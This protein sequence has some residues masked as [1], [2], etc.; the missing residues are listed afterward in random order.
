[1]LGAQAIKAGDA[2]LHRGRRAGEHEHRARTT[3]SRGRIGQK[4]GDTTLKDGVV[5]RRPVV[6][7][8]RLP[9]D[10]AGAVHRREGGAQA[11]RARR[12]SR[13]TSQQKAAAAWAACRF[14]KEIVAVTIP[15]RK[16]DPIV[17]AKDESV[18]A[19]TTL[20]ALAKLPRR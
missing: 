4:L 11:R 12:S 5:L 1:M 6:L 2:A 16:G 3:C 8:Q 19:D 18:R 10:R 20:E 9:H 14:S 17:V 7:V 13:S 15:Q